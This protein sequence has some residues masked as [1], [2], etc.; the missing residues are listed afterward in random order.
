[1]WNVQGFIGVYTTGIEK[2]GAGLINNVLDWLTKATSLVLWAVV[3][4]AIEKMA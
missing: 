2:A 3:H 1:M 4:L